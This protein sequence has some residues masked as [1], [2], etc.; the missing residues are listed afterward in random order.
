MVLVFNLKSKCP[1]Q[2]DIQMSFHE[3]PFRHLNLV[4]T[5]FKPNKQDFD[6]SHK[7]TRLGYDI[8]VTAS[9][10]L[11]NLHGQWEIGRMNNYILWSLK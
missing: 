8:F 10:W 2:I 11:G 6:F 9:E 1:I 5:C 4:I 7:W 3:F